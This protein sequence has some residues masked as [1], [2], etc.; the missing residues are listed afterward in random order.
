MRLP[1]TATAIACVVG[2]ASSCVQVT[3]AQQSNQKTAGEVF[4]NV[5]V[6][7]RVPANQWFDTMAFI[8]GSLGV[9]CDHCHTSS[10][11]LDEGNPAKLKAREMMRM[12][13]EINR[14]HF[15][16]NIVV[17]CNT[18]H[19]GT[20]KP[21]HAPIP[22]AQHWMKAAER[23]LPPPSSDEI[24]AHYRK[25]IELG[26]GE[27]VR[28]QLVSL[29]VATYNGTAP[30]R[31][32][33]L[34]LV[35]EGQNK[36]RVSTRDGQTVKTIIRNGQEAW[37]N[38]GH[39][40]RTMKKGEESNVFDAIDILSPD[41]VGTFESA[42]AVLEDKVDGQRAFVVPVASKDE[43][44]WYFFDARSGILLRQRVFFPSFY[45]DGSV[46]IDYFDYQTF[47]K[48]LLPTTFHFVNAG[49]S[50]LTISHATSRRVNLAVEH[51]QFEKPKE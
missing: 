48:V 28:T 13:D 49:G 27:A 50:G 26:T 29:Q 37:I 20:L 42:G 34:D 18:C 3:G 6:L 39:G 5:Q 10:F 32:T 12:V 16:A 25:S 43:K 9:T 45:G 33:S 23:A 51:T 19:R 15:D 4:K 36:V 38:D 11:D 21:Q 17:T 41:Q 47:G 35:L 30:A 2:L 7:K 31:Q 8:A 40:W 24:L 1:P 22:D 46:D 14:N 44:K